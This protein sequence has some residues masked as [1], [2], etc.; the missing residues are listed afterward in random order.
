VKLPAVAITAAFACGVA[1]GLWSPIA[2]LATSHVSLVSGFLCAIFL[3]LVALILLNRARMAAAAVVSC[4]SWLLLGTLGAWISEHPLPPSHVICLIESGRIDLHTPLRWRGTLRDEPTKLPWGSGLEIELEGL[5]YENSQLEARGG[6]RVSFSPREDDLLLPAL[7]AGDGVSV[8]VQAKRPQVFRDE[9][10]FD[11]RAYLAAHG[12]DLVGTL[13]SPAL[14]ERLSVAPLSSRTLLLRTRRRLREEVDRLFQSRPEVA[15]VLRAM[16]LGDRSFVDRD[17][18]VDFQKTGVF[19]VL[20]VAGLHVGAL[21]FFLYWI[22]RRLRLSRPATMVFTLTFLLAYVAVIEQRPPVLRAALMAAIVVLGGFFY[23]RL[24]VLNSAAIA[25]L[26]LLV[27]QPHALRDS[28]F[29]LTFLA[30]GCIA[31]LAAPWLEGNVHPYAKAL[32]GWRDVTRDAAHEPHAAQFRIDL[33]SA[34]SWLSAR[35]PLRI[36]PHAENALAGGIGLTLRVWE[37]MVLT[38]ALQIGMLPL[39]ARDFHRITLSAPIVNLAAV[40]LTGIVVPLGF[41]TLGSALLLPGLASIIA[42]PLS[43]ITL[44]LLH[45]V[46]WFARSPKWSYRIPGPHLWLVVWF[47]VFALLLAG[48]MRMV[49]P[50]RR[51]IASA[52]TV[53]LVTCSLLIALFPFAPAWSAGKLEFSVLDVGQGDSLFLVSPHGKTML[54][55]GGGAFGGF[56]GQS[57]HHGIDP[58]EEAVSPYLWSRGF[59]KI[60]VVALTHAHQDHLGGLAAV[61]EN[62]RVGQLWIGREVRSQALAT[63]EKLAR[64]RKIPIEH[65]TRGNTFAWDDLQGKFLWPDASTAA[66][67]DAAKNDDSLMLRL[68]YADRALMLPGDAEKGAER[69]ILSENNEDELHAEVLKIGHHGS[70]N[71]TTAEFLAAVKPRL[72][73][74]SV[75]EDNPYGHPNAELLERLANAGVRVL[76]TDRNGA[77]HILMDSKGLEVRCFA[78]CQPTAADDLRQAQAPDHNKDEKQ[79]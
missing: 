17:E 54:I 71:S 38:L 10:A 19:H 59:Q 47:F 42:V 13:R 76:R 33:R 2:R 68:R 63:V 37:L 24:D 53:G 79:Q 56:G 16:L 32:R 21:A 39:M 46:H 73:I 36:A 72:A 3:V 27:A 5:G 77:V 58:G 57:N 45:I 48:S 30:I 12:I 49:H 43:Y 26:I 11:R 34:A 20:V 61:L 23:R 1:L 70:K 9:G 66:P 6:L 7:H 15:A 35:V 31:G 40:P 55:D 69:E 65:E 29:Q 8:I 74:I 18:A 62:F 51:R 44:L 50:L 14:I 60:D 64:D 52:L 28:S 25:A 75:G 22:G 41:F 4:V 67:S 78:L